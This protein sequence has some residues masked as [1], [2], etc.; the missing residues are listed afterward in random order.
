MCVCVYIGVVGGVGEWVGVT[1]LVHVHVRVHACFW[2]DL[3]WGG[4]WCLHVYM[5]V[6]ACMKK[7][8]FIH[9]GMDMSMETVLKF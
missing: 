9:Y 2:M 1:V 6:Y 4:W 8:M 5:C 7:S 3:G